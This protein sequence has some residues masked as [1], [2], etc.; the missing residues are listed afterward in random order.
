MK[1]WHWAHTDY[2]W[3]YEYRLG[4]V[5]IDKVII[6]T[7]CYI[8]CPGIDFHFWRTSFLVFRSLVIFMQWFLNPRVC[9]TYILR[10]PKQRSVFRVTR[11]TPRQNT[12]VPIGLFEEFWR[13]KSKWRKNVFWDQIG[14]RSY[15]LHQFLDLFSFLKSWKKTDPTFFQT[16]ALNRNWFA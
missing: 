7:I 3:W 13:R 11:S 10:P 9:L 4:T 16:V 2:R 8:G 12:T 1:I 14:G 15:F 6:L 5:S